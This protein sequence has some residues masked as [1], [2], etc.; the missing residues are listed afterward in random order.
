MTDAISIVT[1][2][3]LI[4]NRQ[5]ERKDFR[6]LA[7]NAGAYNSFGNIQERSKWILMR[8]VKT[9]LGMSQDREVQPEVDCRV[10]VRVRVGIRRD[11]CSSSLI[12]FVLNLVKVFVVKIFF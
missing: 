1:Q 12:N 6:W 5:L 11:S 9:R 10:N 8:K 2:A 7:G 3:D 4:C